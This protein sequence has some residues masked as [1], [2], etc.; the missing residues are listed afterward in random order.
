MIKSCFLEILLDAILKIA[1]KRCARQWGEEK[2]GW[3]RSR[4][5][6]M[7]ALINLYDGEEKD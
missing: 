4:Q 7:M 2:D 6:M 1:W 5:E 3:Q